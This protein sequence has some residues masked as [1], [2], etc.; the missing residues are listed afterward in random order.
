MSGLVPVLAAP[1][2]GPEH[3][4]THTELAAG[5]SIAEILEQ[6]VPGIG[7]DDWHLVRVALVK[8]GLSVL[9]STDKFHRIRPHAGV[10]VVIRV[11][12][13]GLALGQVLSAIVAVGSS[14]VG[15]LVAG[16][17]VPGGGLLAGVVSGLVTA[18]LTALGG[19]LIN[20]LIS[21]EQPGVDDPGAARRSYVLNGFRNE[22]R[23]GQPIPLVLG[24]HRYA[25]PFAAPSY[26]EIVGDE[27]YVRAL[28]TFG[29]GPVVLSDLRLGETPLAHYSDHEVE[30]REG[31]PDDPP[32]T[33]YPRQVLEEAENVEL[34]RPLPRDSAGNVIDGQPG[35]ETPVVRFTAASATK[36]NLIFALQ[37]GLFQLND[38]G[39]EQALTVDIRIRQRAQGSGTWLDVTTLSITAKKREAFFRQH[40]W[41]LPTRGRW[42][43]EVT[44][45]TDERNSNRIAD[46][47]LLAALQSIRPEA[48]VNVTT[49]LSMVALRLRATY[50]LNGTVDDFNALAHREAPIWNGGAWALGLPRNPAAAFL[51]L[52]QSPANPF[53]LTDAEIDLDQIADWYTWCEPQGLKYDRVHDRPETLYEALR[54]I[55]AAGRAAPR[56]DGV[57]WGVVIDRPQ[58]LVVE[59]I[60]PRTATDIS[61]EQ[62]F[63]DPPHGLRVAFNDETNGYKSAE[64]IV[65]WP[66]HVGDIEITE[67]LALPGKT[68]PAEIYIEARRKMYELVQR[69]IVF[70]ALQDG[71]HRA[72][73]RGD[74]VR[75]ALPSLDEVQQAARVTQVDGDFIELDEVIDWP[76][77][78]SL[79]LRLRIFADEEDGV[80]TSVV[81][82][83]SPVVAAGRLLKAKAPSHMPTEGQHVFLGPLGEDSRLLVIKSV[84]AG[85]EASTVLQMLPA[86]PEIDAL[87]A[88]DVPP[89][90]DGRVGAEIA[91]PDIAPPKPEIIALET[92]LIGT[93]IETGLQVLIAPGTGAVPTAWFRIAHRLVGTADFAEIIVPAVNGGASL[94]GYAVADE[95][96]LQVFARSSG[97][98]ESAPT[99]LLSVA[100]GADDPG[101]P[102]ALD[103]GAISATGGLG[104]AVLGFATGNDPNLA[105]VQVY[106]VPTG[107]ALDRAQHAISSP[108]A[109]IADTTASFVDGDATQAN[110]LAA[111]LFQEAAPWTL[112]IGWALAAGAAT[113]APGTASDLS[114][115]LTLTPGSAYRGAVDVAT[116]AAGTV[117]PTLTGGTAEAGPSL[118]AP[119]RVAFEI[120]AVAG[121][122]AFALAADASFEGVI[123]EALLFKPSA[124]SIP[125]GTYDYYL[126]PQNQRAAPG[127]LAGPFTLTIT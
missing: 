11:T 35:Q 82:E 101:V 26:T 8:D 116:V 106:R 75:L 31:R 77:G 73:T 107:Q 65:P 100:I 17:L 16:F 32:I 126:E 66:G 111:P 104:A 18:G 5:A 80:G 39:D 108:I 95:V 120:T 9:I 117:A 2:L 21:A 6:V 46:R 96:E 93:G 60:S 98:A 41:A 1:A 36:V 83:V 119:G 28:F 47:V 24:R 37:S 51:V 81:I 33:L 79:G 30:I 63:V 110:L 71:R 88:N 78:Q 112:G 43:I 123:G 22:A 23:P 87:L 4:R 49:P 89:E 48:P 70:T 3:R 84:E 42:E 85:T 118:S 68:D 38:E 90:W 7:E 109:V 114:Q 67:A 10:L 52:L 34:R 14:K 74:Q 115:A 44:R 102:A 105:Q 50:E 62:P 94:E 20:N 124:Q 92:G 29:H 54:I 76:V 91:L 19:V 12:P 127:P 121:N 99:D 15:A 69:P 122:D 27:Q 25:P 58:D 13:E 113:H 55:C 64:R 125:Q 61:W 57:K 72:A 59:E 97:G 45:M 56:H 86:A 103:A 40:S 53:P